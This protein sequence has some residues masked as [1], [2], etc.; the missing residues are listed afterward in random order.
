MTYLFVDTNVLLHYRRLEEIDWL[1][2]SKSGEVVIVLCPAV[3]RELDHHKVTHPQNKFRKRAQEI[4]TSLHSRL[5]GVDAD[6]IRDGVRL[7]FL[8]EDPDLDFGAHKLRPELTDDWMIASGIVWKQ[9]HPN[10]ET[11]IVSADLGISIKARVSGIPV[12]APLETD[13]LAEELDSDEKRLMQLQKELAEIRNTL[14]SLSL[15]FWR[16]PQGQNFVRFCIQSPVTYDAESVAEEL[17]RIRSKHPLLPPPD[18]RGRVRLSELERIKQQLSGELSLPITQEDADR[19]NSS[20]GKF[21]QS[22]E[23]YLRNLHDHR[24][25]ELLKIVF[26]TGLENGG[27][28]PAED[29]DIHLHFPDGFQLFDGDDLVP[30]A[31]EPPSPPNRPGTFGF[32][33]FGLR[34]FQNIRLAQ[35][36]IPRVGPPTNVSS[37][38][39]KRTNSYDVRS[40][41]NKAKHGY[42]LRVAKFT[43]IFDSYE[44]A[45]SF[46]IDY[47]ISAA[48]LPKAA[49]G[50]LSVVVEK[51]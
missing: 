7:E 30:E 16:E 49:D 10:D 14:P 48:N 18:K 45:G 27:S 17:A 20:L 22:Y 23:A 6:V 35:S 33:D 41:V 38:F 25:K 43:A 4:I 37:P 8:A 24:N 40:H 1:T 28:A 21:Y 51:A 36:V 46:R 3:I 47:S 29:V 12:F 9:K 13:K 26:E 50:H 11:R 31:P 19:Y 2:L 44:S 42:T 34:A 39:I 5:S 32:G 15:C